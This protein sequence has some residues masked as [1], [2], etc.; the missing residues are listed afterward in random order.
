MVGNIVVLSHDVKTHIQDPTVLA[1]SVRAV[2][3]EFIVIRVTSQPAVVERKEDKAWL[4]T[5]QIMV[6]VEYEVSGIRCVSI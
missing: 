3:W 5:S 2:V 4:R 6:V 1:V